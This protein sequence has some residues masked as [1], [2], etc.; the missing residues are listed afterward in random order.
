MSTE[1]N[2]LSQIYQSRIIYGILYYLKKSK[3]EKKKKYL[4]F[5]PLE[6]WCHLNYA[7]KKKKNS[8]LFSPESELVIS[9]E[10]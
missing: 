6:H 5:L 2:E 3:K 4:Q 1:E 7:K 9:A 10:K 8:P